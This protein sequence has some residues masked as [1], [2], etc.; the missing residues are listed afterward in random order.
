MT[1]DVCIGLLTP[2]WPGDNT[3]NGIATSVYFLAEG[4]R[5]IG[6]T[7]VIIA[8]VR[9]GQGPSDIPVVQ[10]P[11]GGANLIERLRM[12]LGDREGW[13]RPIVRRISAAVKQA[14]RDHGLNVLISE[15]TD[16]K[17]VV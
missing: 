3:P 15:E 13:N 7:P 8:M 12:R 16:R 4:L 6:Y 10:V 1:S 9:D 5:D 11:E 2:A 14:Q 17:S